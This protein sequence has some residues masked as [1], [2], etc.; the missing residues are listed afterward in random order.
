MPQSREAL[1]HL[2]SQGAAGC[3]SGDQ[4][5]ASRPVIYANFEREAIASGLGFNFIDCYGRD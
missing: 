3:R 2:R 1:G 5:N 4:F